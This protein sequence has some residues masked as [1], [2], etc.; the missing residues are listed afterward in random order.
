KLPLGIDSVTKVPV[1]RQLKQEY[2]YGTRGATNPSQIRTD[3]DAV[4]T[5]VTG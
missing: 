1:K 3:F 4:K 5:M 2:G